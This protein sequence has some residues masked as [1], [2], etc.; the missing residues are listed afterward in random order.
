MEERLTLNKKEQNRLVVLN[1]VEKGKMAMREAVEILGI[2]ERQGWRLLAAYREE[3]PQ[4]SA[5]PGAVCAGRDAVAD[6][7]ESA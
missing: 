7:R 6:R 4:A 3:V 5:A 2:S 1:K